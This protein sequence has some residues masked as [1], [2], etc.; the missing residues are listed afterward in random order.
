MTASLYNQTLDILHQ[1]FKTLDIKLAKDN[2]QK[3]LESL[4]QKQS[5]ENPQLTE[6]E[7]RM[8]ILHFYHQCGLGAFVHYD[9]NTL[10]IITHIKNKKHNIY[11]DSICEFL[12]THKALYTQEKIKQ[13]ELTKQDFKELFDFIESS[14]DLQRNTQRELIK[15]ALRN[16]FGIQARDAL[17]FK[18]GEIK[19][20]A[21]DYEKVKINNEIRK[22]NSNAHINVLSNED[23]KILDNALLS[24]DMHTIIVQNT[25]MILQNDIHLSRIDNLEFNKRFS[26]F[27]IQKLRLYI[28]NLAINH[29]DSLAKSIYCMNLAHKYANVMFEVVAK[30]L[31]ELCSKNNANAIKF[32]EFYNGGSLELKGQILKKPLIIDS[33]GNPWTINL[34]QQALRS[35]L[36]IEFDIQKMQQQSDNIDKQIENITRTSNQ[37][38]LSLK[39]SH[40][41]AEYCKN[42]LESKNQALRLL[43]NQKAPKE[44]IDTLSEE[45]NALILKKSQILNTTEELQKELVGLNNEHIK[46]LESKEELKQRINYTFKKNREIFLQYDL[47]CHALGD[48][49]AN[50]KELI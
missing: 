25:L 42:D 34:I 13:G 39:E 12:K 41:K 4:W 36:N 43:V 14:F 26:F 19:L 22:I 17:F 24:S 32:I 16:V 45:I 35:K 44:Q 27:A 20:F 47:L 21:F 10:H 18:D 49:I 48:A 23:K 9:K 46:L 30:E 38:E 15:I 11:V 8:A 5:G 31:L 33:N 50:G 28:E 3:S 2:A 7:I 1:S 6:N 29:I 40:T 37:H